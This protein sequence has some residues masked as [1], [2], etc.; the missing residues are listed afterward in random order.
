MRTAGWKVARTRAS[1]DADSVLRTRVVAEGGESWNIHCSGGGI[2]QWRSYKALDESR[3][4]YLG[5][6]GNVLAP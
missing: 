6:N 5:N 1:T 3:F 4:F 2:L